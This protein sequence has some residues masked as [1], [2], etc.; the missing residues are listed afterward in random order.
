MRSGGFEG[1]V[2]EVPPFFPIVRNEVEVIARNAERA[3][4]S[5]RPKANKGA[6]D[7]APRKFDLTATGSF[8]RHTVGG[9]S[10]G[11]RVHRLEIGIDLECIKVIFGSPAAV[12]CLFELL[13]VFDGPEAAGLRR[14]EAANLCERNFMI[15]RKTVYGA[16]PAH[17]E[18]LALESHHL[19]IQ[20]LERPKTEIPFLD[21]QT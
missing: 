3:R 21:Q 14:D 10:D 6:L 16:V 1:A 8:Q 15:I 5:R 9:W 7:V 4:E 18:D 2:E 19:T 20:V 12:T 17:L 13:E 11:T